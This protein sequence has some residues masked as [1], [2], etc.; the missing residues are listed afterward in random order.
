MAAT[1]LVTRLAAGGIALLAVVAGAGCNAPDS[2]LS[3]QI[4]VD[5]SS[6]VF[7]IAEAVAEEF[8]KV[9]RGVRVNVGLSGTGGGFEKF[10]RGEIQVSDA[11]R[12]IKASEVDACAKNGISDILEIQVAIDALTVAVNPKNTWATCV[13]PAE[14]ALL[15]R[16]GGARKWS[17][18][19]PSW[20]NEQ[21]AFYYPG[22]DSGTF[23]YFREA[24]ITQGGLDKEA[25]HR[26]DGT[27]SEDDNILLKAVEG[28]RDAIAY[29]GFAYA[30]EAGN[31]AKLLEVD[32]GKG[33][34]KPS[35][36]TATDGTYT[37]LSRPLFIY[38]RT[39]L[40]AERPEVARFVEFFLEA[41]GDLVPEVGYVSMPDEVLRAQQAKIAPYAER[42]P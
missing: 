21:I 38:T 17:D 33:C 8:S 13:T 26:G 2:G 23:D 41:N 18:V 5:G 34:V 12:P 1:T 29:F 25:K 20:P 3:G 24:I 27:A 37:P 35:T 42:R 6:T 7:P 15:F 14:L 28:D 4:R 36:A 31:K 32:A 10:C 22:A 9:A 16:D 11:S 19:N 30:Q 39:S 40:L